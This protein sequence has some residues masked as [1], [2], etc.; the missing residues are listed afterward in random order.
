[1]SIIS[2]GIKNKLPESQCLTYTGAYLSHSFRDLKTLY[3]HLLISG[4]VLLDGDILV[5]CVRR[6]MAGKGGGQKEWRRK[7][8]KKEAEWRRPNPTLDCPFSR[9]LIHYKISVLTPFK[10]TTLPLR[11]L[12][13]FNTSS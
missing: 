4:E 12:Y 2:T 5:K 6:Q 7:R 9:E 3:C 11:S 13:H 10:K 8:E 1:M